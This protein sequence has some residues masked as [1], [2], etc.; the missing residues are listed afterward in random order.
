MGGVSTLYRSAEAG[1]LFDGISSGWFPV[2][3]GVRQGCPLS[4]LIFV[5]AVEKL[6]NA[7]RDNDL[8]RGVR[9]LDSTSRFPNLQM[10]RQMRLG[11]YW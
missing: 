9:I 7:I 2:E 4:P 3:R 5:L 8:I 6:V 1:V 11:V 10:S